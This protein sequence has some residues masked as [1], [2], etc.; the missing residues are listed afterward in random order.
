[1]IAERQYVD[2]REFRYDPESPAVRRG[3]R[4][5]L[6]KDCNRSPAHSAARGNGKPRAYEAEQARHRA[7]EDEER[8]DVERRGETAEAAARAEEAEARQRAEA[9]ARRE[10]EAEEERRAKTAQSGQKPQ[11][12]AAAAG[13]EQHPPQLQSKWPRPF[14]AVLIVFGIIQCVLTTISFI[15][16]TIDGSQ[17]L[18]LLILDLST[19]AVG[20]GVIGRKSWSI[21]VGLPISVLGLANG[22]FWGWFMFSRLGFYSLLLLGGPYAISSI[23]YLA[24]IRYFRRQLLSGSENH[25]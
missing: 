2:W 7:T 1:V 23:V 12:A 20:A 4:R 25:L 9:V 21:K 22:L 6:C 14:G 8:R 24:G 16:T 19:I 13:A 10:R 15:E 3:S 18:P 11:P 17:F 5:F